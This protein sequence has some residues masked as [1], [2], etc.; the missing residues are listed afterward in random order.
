[1]GFPTAHAG[2]QGGGGVPPHATGGAHG[3]QPRKV[4]PFWRPNRY[5]G[6]QSR[7]VLPCLWHE[8]EHRW[9]HQGRT[10]ASRGFKHELVCVLSA[11][12]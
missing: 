9:G 11:E 10:A 3:H 4:S 2:G 5:L 12:A 7:G 8:G 1:M 6:S